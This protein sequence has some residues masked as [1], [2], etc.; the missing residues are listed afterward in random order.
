MNPRGALGLFLLAAALLAAAL[1]AAAATLGAYTQ[2]A[3]LLEWLAVV[4][5]CG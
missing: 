2:P 4:S 3:R 1:V 5:L